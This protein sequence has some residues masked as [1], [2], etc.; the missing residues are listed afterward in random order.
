MT[1]SRLAML[2]VMG[3]LGLTVADPPPTLAQGAPGVKAP[4]SC[5]TNTFVTTWQGKDG[6][7]ADASSW[8]GSQPPG[9]ASDPQPNVCISR[10]VTVTIGPE[11]GRVDVASLMLAE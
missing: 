7:W 4:W 3:L 9:D 5:Q 8:S 11:S 10:P 2:L 1:R 6:N